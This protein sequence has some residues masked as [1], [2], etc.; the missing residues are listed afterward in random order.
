LFYE[1]VELNYEANSIDDIPPFILDI[2]DKDFGL[3]EGDDFICRAII[4]ISEASFSEKDEIPRPKWHSCRLKKGAPDCGQ[5]LISFAIV[6]DDYNFK[7]PFK[8]V[9]LMETVQFDEYVI[10]IN[11]LGLRD[12]QSMGFLPVKKAFIQFNLKSLVP[13][14]CS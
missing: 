4:P 14:N 10:E 6:E 7:V 13:P 3:L 9:N 11:V 5:V 8:Y 12:L 1:T 2:Y